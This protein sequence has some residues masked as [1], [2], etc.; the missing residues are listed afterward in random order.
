[1]YSIRLTEDRAMQAVTLPNIFIDEYMK[2]ANA[3]QLK[4]YLYLLRALSDTEPLSIERILDFVNDTE[5]E[6]RRALMYWEK[7]GVLYLDTDPSVPDKGGLERISAI[8]LC[9][10]GSSY[11]PSLP[12]RMVFPMTTNSNESFSEDEV[13]VPSKNETPAAS[14]A[15]VAEISETPLRKVYTTE[16]CSRIKNSYT[17]EDLLSFKQEGDAI[18]V[19]MVAEQYLQHF[20]TPSEMRTLMFFLHELHFSPDLTDYLLQYCIGKDQR[21]FYEIEKVALG[22]YEKN[23]TTVNEAKALSSKKDPNATAIMQM[24][25]KRGTPAPQESAFIHRWLHTY[26]FSM[27][28]ITEACNRTVLSVDHNHFKYAD[29]ILRNWHKEKV[30]TLEDIA[31]IDEKFRNTQRG[32]AASSAST[33]TP[34]KTRSMPR[35]SA[36]SKNSTFCNIEE[37]QYDFS[38]LEEYFSGK[39]KTKTGSKKD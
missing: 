33:A 28:V 31:R 13:S 14:E 30:N 35:A 29:A 3:L 27:E 15:P 32:S 19:L 4:V 24:L 21:A 22:W 26:G 1:M 34:K 8:H 16:E 38:A 37:Q 25:G 7:Q 20:V 9:D 11:T 18:F 2:D 12:G 23:I 5:R 39:G 10:L 17:A 36:P 6:V